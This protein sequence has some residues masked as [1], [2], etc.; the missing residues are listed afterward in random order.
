M[1][2]AS[3]LGHWM[4]A[5]RT[6]IGD[7]RALRASGLEDLR[8]RIAELAWRR[9]CPSATTIV[10]AGYRRHLIA[11]TTEYQALLIAW[12]PAYQTPLHDHEGLWGVELVLD[13]V[14]AVDEYA[15]SDTGTTRLT[16][17][18]SLVLGISDAAAFSGHDYV[19]AC[20]NLSADRTTLSLHI[21][22]GVLSQYTAYVEDGSGRYRSARCSAR[23]D[24]VCA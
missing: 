10:G 20:R 14:L 17:Q 1:V 23:I 18:R 24:A 7:V 3:A 11:S 6:A 12:P 2:P 8:N 9:D 4:E 21:Y 19:H 15:K 22:G 16:P 5:M 13:G